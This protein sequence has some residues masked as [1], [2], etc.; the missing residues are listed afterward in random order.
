MA[1]K[2]SSRG[3]KLRHLNATNSEILGRAFPQ[4]KQSEKD[5]LKNKLLSSSCVRSE[6]MDGPVLDIQMLLHAECL[7][8]QKAAVSEVMCV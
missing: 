2:L 5:L 3:S 4:Q 6:E 8:A 1:P 7:F